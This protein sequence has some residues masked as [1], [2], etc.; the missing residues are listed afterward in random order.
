[1]LTLQRIAAGVGRLLTLGTVLLLGRDAWSIEISPSPSYTGDYTVSGFWTGCYEDWTYYPYWVGWICQNL[2]EQTGSGESTTLPTGHGTTSW[3]VAGKA[4]GTY[5]YYVYQTYGYGDELVVDGPVSVTVGTPVPRDPLLTQL[6]YRFETRQG[7]INFDGRTDLFIKRTAGGVGG[8][9][10]LDAAILRQ[11]AWGDTFS[12]AAP[13]LYESTIAS[14][15]P[16]SSTSVVVT[17][18][19]VDG[20]VDVEIKGV[21]WATGVAADQ[22][23]FSSGA[24]LQAQP[25]GVRA[26]DASLKEFVGNMLDYIVNPNYFDE[27]A[28]L[29]YSSGSTPYLWCDWSS[30]FGIWDGWH[31]G[32]PPC[33]TGYIYWESYYLDYSDFSSAA[34]NT[35]M[36]E[37]AFRSG[38]STRDAALGAIE[39]TFEQVLGV[40]IGGWD[41]EEIT[42][43]GGPYSDLDERRGL[44]AFLVLLGIGEA[45]AQEIE[46]DEAPKPVPREPGVIYVVGR[47]V[48][49]AAEAGIHSVLQYTTP[50]LTAPTWLSAFDSA[51]ESAANDGIL[52]AETNDPR[53]HP[54][55]TRLTLGWVIP[56]HDG[57]RV[58]YWFNEILPAHDYYRQL[59]LAQKAPYD[60]LPEIPCFAICT[61]YNSNG[62]VRGL[63]EATAGHIIPMAPFL[64]DFDDLFGG[65][66]PVPASYF[67]R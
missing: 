67:G 63:V 31:H 34:V 60:A 24:P 15:W 54:I 14:G 40:V 12:V 42:G 45:N 16:Q 66:S 4:P 50:G 38:A 41:L 13:T 58:T 30:F 44:N 7:D 9:G 21:A 59:P 46:T 52:V 18:F 29:A 27:N 20:F 36:N 56:P 57:P 53:D 25:L 26:V 64:E 51:H 8:N 35:W 39:E 5:S 47:Y 32:M 48:F 19:N 1:M 55:L 28:S 10:V 49:V 2:V 6:D 17:D 37:A 23:V 61:D 22:I 43:F 65:G 3:S 11:S 33:T 62:Y